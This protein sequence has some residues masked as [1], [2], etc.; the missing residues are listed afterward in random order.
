MSL[1]THLDEQEIF[2]DV[3]NIEWKDCPLTVSLQKNN[4]VQSQGHPLG[5]NGAQ[6][7]G[8]C[9]PQQRLPIVQGVV[10]QLRRVLGSR[11]PLHLYHL[12]EKDR[13]C[14]QGIVYQLCNYSRDQQARSRL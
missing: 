8:S 6:D 9:S 4:M 1:G 13:L 14:L 3:K 11:H 12:S 7:L 10:S 5:V 2:A